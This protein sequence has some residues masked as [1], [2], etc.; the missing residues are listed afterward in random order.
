MGFPESLNIDT[1]ALPRQTLLE[2][3]TIET[4]KKTNTTIAGN[5]AECEMH[6]AP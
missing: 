2:K 4:K 3:R 1:K 6:A 5:R